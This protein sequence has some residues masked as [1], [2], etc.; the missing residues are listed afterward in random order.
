MT[1]HCYLGVGT[2]RT[3]AGAPTTADAALLTAIEGASD[4]I[5][6]ECSRTFQPYTATKYFSP[7]GSSS[8]TLPIGTDL[9]AITTLKTDDDGD[10]VFETTWATTDYVLLPRNALVGPAPSP[11][12]QIRVAADGD[13]SFPVGDDLVEIVGTWGYALDLLTLAATTSEVLDASETGVDVSSV[14]E[15]EVGNTIQVDSEQMYVTAINTLTLTVERG[16]NG[17]TAAT[18][19]T[20]ATI[21]RHRY[22]RNIALATQLLAM[23][24]FRRKDA[25]F[26]VAGSGEMGTLIM[27]PRYDSDYESKLQNYRLVSVA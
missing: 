12:W 8:L 19:L 5:D 7:T 16:V 15:I 25:P 26:G 21:K 22:P 6:S 13:Y 1:A 17:T 23:K 10:G 11:Y 18:H 3:A 4:T 14:S 2:L 20:A 24:N 9:I 27:M